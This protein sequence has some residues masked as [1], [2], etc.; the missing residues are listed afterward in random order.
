MQ[1]ALAFL[2]ILLLACAQ[3]LR[4]ATLLPSAPA[5]EYFGPHNESVLEIQNRLNAFDARD[6]RAMYDPQVAASLDDLRLAIGDWQRRYPQ[7]PWLP[8]SLAHLMHEYLRA[9]QASSDG[10]LATISL[11]RSAYPNALETLQTSAMIYGYGPPAPS[12]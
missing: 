9:G 1:K 8:R 11:M 2:A 4:A 7:D 3:G 5:D 12:F 6:D 10:A